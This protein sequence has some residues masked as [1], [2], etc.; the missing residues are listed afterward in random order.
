MGVPR[1]LEEKQGDQCGWS[2]VSQGTNRRC[3]QRGKGWHIPEDFVDR[4]TDL[5]FY[6]G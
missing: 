1:V 6:T 3:D 4:R 5:G 2:R